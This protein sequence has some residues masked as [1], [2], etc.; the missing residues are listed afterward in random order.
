[1]GRIR[2]DSRLILADKVNQL[3]LPS[4]HAAESLILRVQD[5]AEICYAA[6]HGAA[7]QIGYPPQIKEP[8]VPPSKFDHGFQE[9]TAAAAQAKRAAVE[10]FRQRAEAAADPEL[11]ARREA[12]AAAQ[13]ARL[14]KR[15]E[16]QEMR[17][18][19]AE[20]EKAAKAAAIAAAAAAAEAEKIAAK[21]RAE[22]L[23]KEQKAARDARYAA[24]K[25]RK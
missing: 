6:G 9:R 19:R 15:A 22:A 16:A 21:E 10:Q 25:A 14:L 4:H 2:T 5:C 11:I 8:H 23:L 24:R 7:W 1:M 13:A 20:E 18:L 12:A 3:A 17:K